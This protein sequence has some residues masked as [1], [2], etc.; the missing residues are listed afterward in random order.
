MQ[1]RA[2][3]TFHLLLEIPICMI[4]IVTVKRNSAWEV[5]VYIFFYRISGKLHMLLLATW[6]LRSYALI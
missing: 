3:C 1:S 5:S 6:L 4:Y 2:S